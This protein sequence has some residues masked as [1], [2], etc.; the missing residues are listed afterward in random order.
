VV[1]LPPDRVRRF[2]PLPCINCG[3]CVQAC[4]TRLLPGMISK[5]CEYGRFEEAEAA[6]LFHCIE[7][8]LCAY[9]CPAKRPMIH[10]FRHAKEEIMVRRAGQ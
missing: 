9:V 1:I 4:P 5:Y 7:C 3:L 2:E 8:G 10:Y 6:D